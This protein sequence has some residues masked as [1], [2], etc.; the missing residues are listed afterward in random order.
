[1]HGVACWIPRAWPQ[2]ELRMGDLNAPDSAP[3]RRQR[4]PNAGRAPGWSRWGL[5]DGLCGSLPCTHSD[6]HANTTA[7]GEREWDLGGL[8]Q[9]PEQP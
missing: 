5:S 2:Q 6:M 3:S 8:R 7:V 1:M 9:L 4:M